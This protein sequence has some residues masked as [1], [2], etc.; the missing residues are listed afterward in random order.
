MYSIQIPLT[1]T[2]INIYTRTY[3]TNNKKRRSASINRSATCQ[4]CTSQV[5][6]TQILIDEE[7]TSRRVGGCDVTVCFKM[8]TPR[9][10]T[11]EPVMCY[12]ASTTGII[13]SQL[14][15]TRE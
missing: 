14:R 9:N 13:L 8:D 10:I 15:G 6:E 4:Y 3:V 11:V 1:N 2:A 12:L 7:T 5:E